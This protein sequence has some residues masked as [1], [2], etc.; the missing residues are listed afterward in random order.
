M[1]KSQTKI[2]EKIFYQT[3]RF[4]FLPE[5]QTCLIILKS[6]IWPESDG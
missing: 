6:E 5:F 2:K 4:L 1:L 3:E